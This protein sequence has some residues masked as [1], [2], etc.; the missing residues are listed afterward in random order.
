MSCSPGEPVRSR[1]VAIIG[2]SLPIRRLRA[3]IE[4]VARTEIPVLIQGPTGTG[5][6]LVARALHEASE[7]AGKFVPFNVCALSDSMF[8]DALFGH[9]RGAFT[10][11]VRDSR[12]YLAEAHRGTVFLDEVGGLSPSSQAKLL[13]AIETGEF[14]PVGSSSDARSEFRVLAAINER[15]SALVDSRHFRRDLAYRLGGIVIEVPALRDRMQDVPVLAR[16]FAGRLHD[17]SASAALDAGAVDALLSHDWPGNVRELKH[18]IEAASALGGGVTLTR[19]SVLAAMRRGE[20][21]AAAECADAFA[22]RR[23]EGVLERC[24]W[25]TSR[26]AAELGVSR[27]TVYRRMERLCLTVPQSV[28]LQPVEGDV[29]RKGRRARGERREESSAPE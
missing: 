13:R 20:E 12:G 7:R 9:V 5:K 22:R 14:R 15:L 29:P 10:G 19:S 27:S 21:R 17:R 2:E 6:E 26:V 3:M 28:E 24:A 11:A 23:F 25:D 4:R 1:E 8:E 18:V 16:H